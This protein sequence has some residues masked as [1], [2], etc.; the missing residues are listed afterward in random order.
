MIVEVPN[1]RRTVAERRHDRDRRRL[2]R[3]VIV[4]RKVRVDRRSM[5]ER[6]FSAWEGLEGPLN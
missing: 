6:K 5:E 1:D 3:R 2:D 4:R